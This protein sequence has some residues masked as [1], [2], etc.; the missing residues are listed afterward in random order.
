MLKFQFYKTD[1]AKQKET[2]L[3]YFHEVFNQ[4]LE[5]GDVEIVVNNK[6]S[7]KQNSALHLYF[8]LLSTELNNRG[9]DFTQVFKNPL[10]IMITPEIVKECMWK[11]IQKAMFKTKSTT[12]LSK[13][14]QID[15][16]YDV[17][18]KK[19]SE[20]FGVYVPF[21]SNKERI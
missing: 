19:L 17:I 3:D 13:Q 10:A 4:M 15:K 14:E 6:R 7:F 5:K 18:N 20:D 16:I 21:P 12:K 9:L 11:P 1:D 8:Q 2:K